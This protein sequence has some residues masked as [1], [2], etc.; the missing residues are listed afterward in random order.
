MEMHE[1]KCP[2]CGGSIVFDSGAQK[3]KCPY[4]DTEFD[5]E[6]LAAYDQV[7][8]QQPAD[9]MTWGDPAPGCEWD[10]EEDDGVRVYVCESCGGEIICDEN[11]AATSCPFCGNPVIIMGKLQGILKPDYVIPFKLDK[12]AAKEGLR[13]HLEGKKLLPKIFRDENHIDEIK[14]IY[15]PFWVFDTDVDA[16]IRYR[17]TLVRTWTD[18]FYQYT[19]TAHYSVQRSGSLGFDHI[20]VDGSS[21]MADELMDSIEPFDFSEAVDF[22]TAYLSGYL[23]D[24]YDVGSEESMERVNGRV[25]L[26]TEEVFCDT[27]VGYASVAPEESG[28]RLRNSEAKYALFP[29]WLLNT[30]WQDKK[31]TFVM[32]GQTGKFVGDLP[33]DRKA[34]WKYRL[35]Y[36]GI[37]AAVCFGLGYLFWY[38]M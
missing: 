20:P 27:V 30:T 38:F 2:C 16:D 31:Y 10:S 37:T 24:K 28:V 36:S 23:A 11:T 35:L 4:C 18:T 1:Y 22:R 29:V 6:T 7:L 15:V 9:N 32:N 26:T 3:M 17:A 21:R 33:V 12:E 19:E 13:K 8:S 34:Y 25:K 14:G 5:V